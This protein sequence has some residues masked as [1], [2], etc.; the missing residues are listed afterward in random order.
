M[1]KPRNKRIIL[2]D[3]KLTRAAAE[4]LIAWLKKR[5]MQGLTIEPEREASLVAVEKVKLI[6]EEEGGKGD[7]DLLIYRCPEC[8]NFDA[9]TQPITKANQMHYPKCKTREYE[10]LELSDDGAPEL[11]VPVKVLN[12]QGETTAVK[13]GAE[14]HPNEADHEIEWIGLS[15]SESLRISM[16]KKEGH[17]VFPAGHPQAPI[18]HGNPMLDGVTG[19]WIYCSQHKLWYAGY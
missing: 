17:L 8:G 11:H 7:P 9:A 1:E 5:K 15:T 10:L 2:N 3:L 14:A 12:A 4:R 19:I 13:V 6:L 18:D 16:L